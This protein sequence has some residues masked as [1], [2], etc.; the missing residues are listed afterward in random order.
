VFFTGFN[1]DRIWDK[2]GKTDALLI[3]KDMSGASMGEFRARVAFVHLPMVFIGARRHA[4]IHRISN[5]P[6]MKPWSIGGDY[7][8]PVPRRLVE[9]AG[10]P[11]DAFGMEKKATTA[12]VHLD[13]AEFSDSTR[14]AI[15]TF[16]DA[17]KLSLGAR[18]GHAADAAK[19]HGGFFV[20]RVLR[21]LKLAKR[22][23]K[24]A[25]TPFAVHSHTRLGPMPMIW[26]VNR[27][28]DERYSSAAGRLRA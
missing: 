15:A 5:D 27:I 14:K 13:V 21:K 7:D 19:E 22:F 20:L 2:Y 18:L 23:P 17:A 28:A 6:S 16:H 12:L 10:V 25:K 24:F 3:R 4:E 26:A 8:R 9:E 1:G 11:R